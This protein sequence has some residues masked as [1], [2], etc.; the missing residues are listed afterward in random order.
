MNQEV[1]DEIREAVRKF[2]MPRRNAAGWVAGGSS[3]LVLLVIFQLWQGQDDMRATIASDLAKVR[4]TQASVQA[5][6]A[7]QVKVIGTLVKRLDEIGTNYGERMRSLELDH[8]TL[9]ENVRDMDYRVSD[10]WSETRALRDS[11]SMSGIQILPAPERAEVDA[12]ERIRILV[13]A[14][15]KMP[16][17]AARPDL[18]TT[19]GKPKVDALERQCPVRHLTSTERDQAWALWLTM[20]QTKTD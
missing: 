6:Q 18:W 11:L 12:V 17:K 13:A 1:T 2:A 20:K 16:G 19:D 3:S 9:R 8:N 4:E 10:A 14:I 7:D 5:A 15:A